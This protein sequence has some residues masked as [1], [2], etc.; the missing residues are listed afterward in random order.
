[1]NASI[2]PRLRLFGIAS[3]LVLAASAAMAQTDE[4][5]PAAAKPESAAKAGE[6]PEAGSKKPA[7]PVGTGGYATESEA[8]AHCKGEVVWVDEHHFNHYPGSREYGRK[9]GAFVCEKG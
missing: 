2:L 8:R 4:K 9:P 3:I 7:K 1:M 6:K 5:T